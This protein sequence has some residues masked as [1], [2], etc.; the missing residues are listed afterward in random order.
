[1]KNV[2]LHLGMPKT[3]TTFLQARYFPYLKGIRYGG[4]DMMALIDRIIYTN[5]IFLD[6]KRTEQEAQSILSNIDEESLLISHE[7]LFGNMLRNY[8]DNVYLTGCLKVVFPEAKLIIVIRRQDELV[9]SIYKQT[10]QSYY[11]QKVSSFLNYRDK[12]FGDSC[13]Q[14]GL[15]N[16]DVKQLNLHRYVQ[17]YVEHFGRDK[18]AVLPYELLRHDQRGFLERLA[19]TLNVE[20]FYPANNYQENRSY[21]W[22]SCKIALLLNRFVRVEGDGSRLLQFI[23]N[24]PFS[25][26]LNRRPSERRVYKVLRGINRRLTLRH[27][28]QNGLDR[29]IYTRRN[30]ISEKKRASIMAFHKESNTRLDK[31]FNLNLKLFGYY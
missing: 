16:L 18:V 23:P 22:L 10:L 31:E 6:L 12:T 7:R 8:E 25:S 9:E 15:P 17:N 19:A 26:F 13:D 4:K 5:P 29:I 20:P 27:V 21:S 28:L 14:L 3:G 24:K 1:M 2:Y 30:L 11:H